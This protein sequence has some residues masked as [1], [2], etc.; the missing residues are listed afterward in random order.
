MW[1]MNEVNNIR[2][3]NTILLMIILEINCRSGQ[4]INLISFAS[5]LFRVLN[6]Y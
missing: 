1:N 5:S 3:I 2:G 6:V 4:S